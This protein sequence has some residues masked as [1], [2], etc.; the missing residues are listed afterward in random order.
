MADVATFRRHMTADQPRRPSN[1]MTI[2]AINQ[3]R[4]P[5]TMADPI[6]REIAPSD[7]A[8]LVS[9]G[10]AVIDIRATRAFSDRHVPGALNVQLSNSQFEQRVGWVLPDGAPFLLA[11][12]S[13]DSARRAL[14]KLAFLGLDARV[15]GWV[16]VDRWGQAGLAMTVLPLIAPQDLSHALT[17]GRVSVLDV[18]PASEWAAG[19][20]Q[21]AH[22]TTLDQLDRSVDA[23][24]FG[25]GTPITVVCAGGSASSTAAS[26]LLRH[27]FTRVSNLEGGMTAWKVAGFPLVDHTT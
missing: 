13:R 26:L 12:E 16:S 10:T 7:A 20:V 19:H 6:A 8:A 21:S 17:E 22:H 18:R 4:Q 27:G 1:M 23:L 9:A 2:V 11:A 15:S 25:H 5:L 3:G 14:H 24:P